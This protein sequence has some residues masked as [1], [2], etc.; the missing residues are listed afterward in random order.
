MSDDRSDNLENPTKLDDLLCQ[1]DQLRQQECESQ[2]VAED[3]LEANEKLEIVLNGVSEGIYA[4]SPEGQVLFANAAAAL[5]FGYLSSRAMMDDPDALETINKF[6]ITDET[7]RHVSVDELPG[8]LALLG[9]RPLEKTLCFL[10]LETGE[11]HWFIVTAAPILN[12]DG[13]VRMSVIL[14]RDITRRKKAAEE[15]ERLIKELQEAL[16]QVKTLSGFLPICSHCHKIRDDEGYWQR[17][18]EYIQEHTD[19]QFSHGI[20]PDCIKELYPD[21]YERRQAQNPDETED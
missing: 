1:L 2:R 5:S 9:Q 17:V 3:L 19:A 14:R 7:G 11:E 16:A 18:E 4:L 6:Q 15:R 10:S 8:R 21:Y 12:C 13:K 20:C